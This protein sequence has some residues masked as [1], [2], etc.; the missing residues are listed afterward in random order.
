MKPVIG[1]T[2]DVDKDGKHLLNNNYV[3][4]IIRAGGLPFII[5]IGIEGDS[6]Q[7]ADLIDGLFLTGGGDIDPLLFGEEPHPNLGQVTPAR[8]IVELELARQMMNCDKPILGICRGLQVLNVAAGGTIYQD[9]YKQHAQPI[10]QHH[11]KAPTGHA[12]HYVQL[13]KGSFLEELAG[14]GRILVNSF[15]HQSL[16][17]VPEPFSVTGVSTDQIIETIES[18]QHQFVIG[19]QWH[20]ERLAENGDSVSMGIFNR[21]IQACNNR[22]S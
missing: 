10:L 9:I 16:K 14:S 8:D 18:A 17:D 6:A 12:T 5:P 11:Q 4:A 20:P 13:K 7:V 2:T 22:K 1:I 21:F 15:H 3:Q 19:V